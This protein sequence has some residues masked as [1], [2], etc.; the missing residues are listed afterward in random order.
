[1]VA[2]LSPILMS[3]QQALQVLVQNQAALAPISTPVVALAPPAVEPIFEEL[4]E[5]NY[6]NTYNLLPSKISVSATDDQTIF[7]TKA[8]VRQE[9]E[10]VS[11]AMTCCSLMLPYLASVA[12]KP[13]L[14]RYAVP[15]FE[16]FDDQRGSREHVARFIDVMGPSL[17]MHICALEN[18]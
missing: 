6:I 14:V 12:T 1:M 15:N 8:E 16:K 13:Y 11:F 10:R 17:I 7:V 18:F 9:K 4:A 5:K 3:I 2:Q